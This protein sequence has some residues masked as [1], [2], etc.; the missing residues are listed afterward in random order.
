MKGWTGREACKKIAHESTTTRS[1][2]LT[3]K[4]VVLWFA[5]HQ[6][7]IQFFPLVQPSYTNVKRRG[8][9]MLRKERP[10]ENMAVFISHNISLS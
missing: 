10:H 9:G 2:P 1:G 7:D 5:A 8:M 6:D 3:N 4:L